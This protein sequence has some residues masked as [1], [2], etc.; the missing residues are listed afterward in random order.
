MKSIRKMLFEKGEFNQEYR[1]ILKIARDKPAFNELNAGG[2][3]GDS[4][5]YSRSKDVKTRKNGYLHY[6][7]KF[8]GKKVRVGRVVSLIFIGVGT[9]L[10]GKNALSS[11]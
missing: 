2:I 7:K 5:K 1:D 11:L 9:A 4:E 3:E 10:L 6:R 8:L